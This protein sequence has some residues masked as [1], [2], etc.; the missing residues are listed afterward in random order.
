MIIWFHQTLRRQLLGVFLFSL[1]SFALDYFLT[2]TP[3]LRL[4][5]PLLLQGLIAGAEICGLAFVLHLGASFLQKDYLRNLQETELRLFPRDSFVFLG[6]LL[7]SALAEEI[8]FRGYVFH[9]FLPMGLASA[10]GLHACV[11]VPCFYIGRRDLFWLLIRIIQSSLLAF[12]FAQSKSLAVPITASTLVILFERFL[13]LPAL[14]Q[15]RST[16]KLEKRHVLR[17]SV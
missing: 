5:L 4:K 7:L 11:L 14:L 16:L 3:P 12:A 8:F 1:F 17:Q 10:L 15:V 2:S 9:F 6:S 13:L